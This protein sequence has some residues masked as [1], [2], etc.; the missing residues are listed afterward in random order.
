[1][2]K[3]MLLLAFAAITLSAAEIKVLTIGNS[4]TWSLRKDLPAVVNAQGD[5]ITLAFA[6]HGGCTIQKH[7]RYASEEEAK[8]DVKRYKYKNK[9][10]KLRDILAAEKW[11]IITIQQA[12]PLSWKKGSFYPELDKLVVYV[13][14]YAPNSEIVFQQ[15]WAYRIDDSRLKKWGGQKAMYKGIFDNYVEAADKFGFRVI[16]AG[17]AVELAR[18]AQ[19]VKFVPVPN[20]QLEKA[21]SNRKAKVSQ[22]GSLCVGWR[23][24]KNR[25]TKAPEFKCDSIHLNRRGEYLQACVWYGFLFNKS[26]LDIKY[27]NEAITE[28]DAV[29]LRKCADKALKEYKQT[30]KKSENASVEAAQS[31]CADKAHKSF[32]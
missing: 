15:T 20:D 18:E 29:M 26:P 14:K 23:W 17:L 11:D 6:N 2:K 1:M 24:T 27:K 8:E 3:I 30:A 5:K 31:V 12:S 4:F 7:W 28:E 16:P 13:K 10:A 21:K 22:P 32:K 25:K 19:P 9:P